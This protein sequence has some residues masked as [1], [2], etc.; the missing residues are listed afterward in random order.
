MYEDFYHLRERAFPYNVDASR[1]FM[2]S[3]HAQSLASLQYSLLTNAGLILVSAESGM[4]K[5]ILIRRAQAYVDDS[6]VFGV[7]TNIH[8]DFRSL[9]PWI[10]T[11][12]ELSADL[13]SSASMYG[14]LKKFLAKMSEQGRHVTLAIDEA[15]NLSEPALQ[16]IKLLLNL[17]DNKNKGLQMVLVGSPL[18]RKRLMHPSMAE[19]AQRVA[20]DFELRPLDFHST[21]EYITYHLEFVNGKPDLFDY[22][23]RATIFYHSRG[24]PRL[25]NN[26][27]D[28]SLVFGFGEA[29]KTIN[30][31]LVK[32]VVQSSQVALHVYRNRKHTAEALD[33]REPI[34]AAHNLDIAA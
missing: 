9:L 8:P 20:L 3:S 32:K 24:I 15:Q 25:I 19:V 27:C 28:L 23:S 13:S 1:F 31:T 29:E 26:I 11:T 17:N 12:F 14:E 18:L 2:G 10:A 6:V 21:N 5:S 4:G 22:F 33:L 34:L 30:E 16:E 7:L